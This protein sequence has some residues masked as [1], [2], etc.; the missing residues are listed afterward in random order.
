[1]NDRDKLA[2]SSPKRT[3]SRCQT[4]IGLSSF[5]EVP[6]T[7]FLSSWRVLREDFNSVPWGMTYSALTQR[8]IVL[9]PRQQEE[10]EASVA[11][12]FRN[13]KEEEEETETDTESETLDTTR[14]SLGS[15]ASWSAKDLQQPLLPE[16]EK[17]LSIDPASLDNNTLILKHH[18][19]NPVLESLYSRG[20]KDVQ[21]EAATG[22]FGEPPFTNWS[23]GYKETLDYIFA[24]KGDDK[25]RLLGLLSMPLVKEMGRGEPQEGRFPS[26]HVCEMVEIALG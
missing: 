18:L 3:N 14:D 13:I 12:D 22:T 21:Q 23:H 8:P 1:M 10:L 24:I 15:T 7:R 5:V 6:S 4:L 19:A 16:Q 11:Y 17:A 26:D 9:A 25:V 20:L 2:F